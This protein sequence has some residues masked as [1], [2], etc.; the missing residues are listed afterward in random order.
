MSDSEQQTTAPQAAA[1]QAA[2]AGSSTQAAAPQAAA[3]EPVPAVGFLVVAFT[4]EMAADQA[5]DAMKAAK[6]Q[7]QFYFEDAAVI[8]QDA[9][10]KVK[11]HETG[12]MSTGKGAGIGALVGGVLGILGGPAGVVLG[13]GAGAAVGG[14]IAHPDKGFRNESLGTLGVALK[15]GTSAIAAITSHDFLKAV[16]Q[17]VAV[18]DIRAAVS[19]LAAELSARLGENMNVAI[20]LLLTADGL[21][22]KEIAANEETAKVVGAVITADAA[23]VGAAVVTADGVAYDIAVATAEGSAG[24]AGVIT[25]EGATVTDV[26][27]AA[28]DDKAP[29][30]A[31]AAPAATARRDQRLTESHAILQV[32]RPRTGCH[33]GVQTAGIGKGRRSR[34]PLPFP[35]S[36]SREPETHHDTRNVLLCPCYVVWLVVRRRVAVDR[37]AHGRPRPGRAQRAGAGHGAAQCGRRYPGHE[38]EFFWH[39]DAAVCAGGFHHPA[40]DRNPDRALVRQH[41]AAAE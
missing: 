41:G 40:A 23:V 31:D 8:R 39:H 5:L 14:A 12:D 21:A 10:G 18:E 33:V 17:N 9:Q 2:G 37:H 13:A 28:E 38:P 1:P 29:G 25:D 6:K 27:V 26:V 16:Q 35:R 15:P 20:G 3:P 22:I 4:D 32:S 34:D 30:A 11:Y 19:N 36:C 7:Q 24:E